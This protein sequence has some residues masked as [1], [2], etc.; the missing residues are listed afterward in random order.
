MSR[1]RALEPLTS[2]MSVYVRASAATRFSAIVLRTGRPRG[3]AASASGDPTGFDVETFPGGGEPSA[4]K[5]D[6]CSASVFAT[7]TGTGTG[8]AT[9]LFMP[10]TFEMSRDGVCRAA[11]ERRLSLN[12]HGGKAGDLGSS[13]SP[14][15]TRGMRVCSPRKARASEHLATVDRA[16][17]PAADSHIQTSE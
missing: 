10:M 2:P 14:C 13:P 11:R 12:A 5:S 4:V 16:A 6:F 1:C 3:V 7:G 9:G 8:T 17:S 15:R